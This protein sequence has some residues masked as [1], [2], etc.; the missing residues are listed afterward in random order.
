MSS[1][2]KVPDAWDDDWV[3]KADVG[4]HVPS[5]DNPVHRIQQTTATTPDPTPINKKLTKA[6][7]RAK[8]AEFNRQLWED[9]SVDSTFGCS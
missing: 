8:Q 2:G 9:A 4:L 7:R 3:E 5:L 6:E 1:G